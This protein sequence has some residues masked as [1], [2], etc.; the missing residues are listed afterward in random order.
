MAP[1]VLRLCC[2]IVRWFPVVFITAIVFWSYY[3]YVIQMCIFTVDNIGEKVFYLILY[4]PLLILFMWSYAR[5]IFT[6]TGKVPREFF[7]S[8]QDADRIS[9]EGNE[10]VTK[11]V[12]M[13]AARGLP[14]LN[15]TTTGFPR[16]CE[17]CKCIKPDRCHH[18]SVCGE[19]N[20]CVGFSNYKFF[21]QFLG[22]AL[23]YC[24][25]V[26]ATS[27]KYFIEFWSGGGNSDMGKFHILFLF[28]VAIMFGI[29]LISLFGYHIY[30][31]LNNRST[32]ESFRSPIF[33]SGPDK[34]GFSLGK[35]NNFVE[36]FGDDKLK[37]FL[38]IFNSDRDG[39][40]FP[41]RTAQPNCYQ[42]MGQTPKQPP[43]VGDGVTYP[44]RT[45]DLDSD[46]L[47][48]D[49]QRWMEEGD[50]DGS[51]RYGAHDNTAINLS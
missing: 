13:N 51:G 42:T 43:S 10:E 25:Y 14:L 19:V 48:A 31:S 21:V 12:L 18:C 26:A 22:Y 37:W 28:F 29:S 36:V 50:V 7:L 9:R 27:L 45:V 40:S 3:A 32:L 15:R 23:V 47:L 49:R 39:V 24:L 11:S 5:T 35:Y 4:H 6:P 2:D 16:Y 46:G 41:T 33:Q 17:K 20:N 1:R 34:Y 44:T 38:P 30:L 8:K